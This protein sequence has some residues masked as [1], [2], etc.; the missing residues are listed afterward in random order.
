MTQAN[1]IVS[2][3]GQ[4]KTGKS[5][6]A[7]SFPPPIRVFNFDIGIEPVLKKY[8]DKDIRVTSYPIPIVDS[9][10][11]TGFGKEISK[12]W[13]QFTD[14]LKAASEDTEIK[15]IIIDTWTA[16]YEL[17]RIA[18]AAELG[19]ENLLQFQYGDVYAR[20]RAMIQYPRIAGQN[21]VLTTYLRDRYVNEANTGELELDGWKRTESEVDV[22][23]WTSRVQKSVA[24]GKKENKIIT[25]IKDNR[26]DLQ[27]CGV[28]MEMGTYDDL[29]A[30]L[31][32]E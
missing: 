30:L 8:P 14:D 18:R 27:I 16:V 12:I 21:L 3:S 24:G 17:A 22:V 2:I 6:L 23:L 15:T 20:L 25:L 1:I 13:N 10:K 28:E 31:G 5:H 26:F 4:P 11:A 29:M 32:I 9:V 7:L 19:Q